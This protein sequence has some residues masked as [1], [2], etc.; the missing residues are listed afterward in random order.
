M[1]LGTLLF[2][3]SIEQEPSD[4]PPHLHLRQA[5]ARPLWQIAN[6]A[7]LAQP[8]IFLHERKG[9]ICFTAKP[10]PMVRRSFRKA[11]SLVEAAGRL[12]REAGCMQLFML[13][14]VYSSLGRRTA[15]IW[16]R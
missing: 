2:R 4:L 5:L 9:V 14:P 12:G 11:F 7:N 16:S 6:L 15:G 8:L 10:T 13:R 3:N 1:R